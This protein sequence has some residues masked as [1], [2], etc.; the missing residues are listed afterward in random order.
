MRKVRAEIDT[1]GVNPHSFPDVPMTPRINALTIDAAPEASAAILSA[2]RDAIGMV[3]NLHATLAH[4][5]A[6]LDA[7]VSMADSLADGVLDKQL[8]ES[9]A[10]AVAA[11]NGCEYCASAHTMLGRGVG[12]EGAEL[13]RHLH[14]T[15]QDPKTATALAFVGALLDTRGDVPDAQ[16]EDMRDAG[17]GDAEIAEVVTHVGMNT[18]TNMFNVFARTTIDFPRVALP[19]S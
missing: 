4:A 9:I 12:I 7:Y 13:E 1:N 8:R 2:V 5:P 10:I 15:S 16:L 3:P 17:F 11:R 19:T 14:G 6:A 18:F